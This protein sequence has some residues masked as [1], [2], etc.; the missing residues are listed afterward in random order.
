[1]G[2]GREHEPLKKRF[3]V[4]CEWRGHPTKL[5]RRARGEGQSSIL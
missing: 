1:M 2:R 5:T 3:H 4:C